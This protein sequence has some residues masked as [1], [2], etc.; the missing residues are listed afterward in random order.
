MT[1]VLI[2]EAY[3]GSVNGPDEATRVKTTGD[4]LL[5]RHSYLIARVG[6]GYGGTLLVAAGQAPGTAR[7]GRSGT[8]HR[9]RTRQQGLERYQSIRI[10]A[11]FFAPYFRGGL[12]RAPAFSASV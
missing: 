10:T 11:G 1:S 12:V 7:G 3:G 2:P 9:G 8:I 4:L 6:V 5:A